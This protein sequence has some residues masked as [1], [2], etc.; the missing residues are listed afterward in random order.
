MPELNERLRRAWSAFSDDI[1][2]KYLKGYGYPSTASRR[3]LR[4]VLAELSDGRPLRLLDLG[5]GNAQLYEFFRETGLDF[6]YT[7]VDFSDVLLTAA[8]DAL[9][10]DSNVELIKGDIETLEGISGEFDFAIYSHVIELLSCPEASLRNARRVARRIAI[11]FYEPPE[12]DVDRVELRTMDV[13]D[14][15]TEPY[16]RRMM[17]RDY[18][19]LIL[20]KIGCTRVDIYQEAGDKDQIHILNFD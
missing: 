8:I 5:C 7:G 19:R 12:F 18:Y 3:L 13:G 2:K 4:E 10:D 16:L 14:G 11:R 20:A 15:R 1:A 6:R 17:S 9:R